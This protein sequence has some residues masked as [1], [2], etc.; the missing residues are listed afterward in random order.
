MSQELDLE[1]HSFFD[2]H[3][4]KNKVWSG[5]VE[6]ML[7]TYILYKTIVTYVNFRVLRSFQQL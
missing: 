4:H 6:G 7:Y 1:L 5:I 3:M 2:G